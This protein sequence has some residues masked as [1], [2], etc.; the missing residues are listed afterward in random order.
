[1]ALH[2]R[3]VRADNAQRI[4]YGRAAGRVASVFLLEIF[5]LPLLLSYL[6]PLWDSRNQTLQ[7]KMASTIVVRT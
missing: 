5:T 4:G 2:I 7:D 6:W 1:M 3:V